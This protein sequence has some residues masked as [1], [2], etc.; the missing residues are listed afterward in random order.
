MC[1]WICISV[2]TLFF[3]YHVR[4]NFEETGS[5]YVDKWLVL[6]RCLL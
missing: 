4:A 2:C 1:E 3:C 5:P 6:I